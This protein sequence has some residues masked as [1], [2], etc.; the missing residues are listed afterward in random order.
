MLGSKFSFPLGDGC[1]SLVPVESLG[2]EPALR[3]DNL[4]EP[5]D[6]APLLAL[7]LLLFVV[8]AAWI[9]AAQLLYV[10][11]YGPDTPAAPMPFLRD[12]LATSRGWL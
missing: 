1:V 3:R 9:G 12:V 5:L 10:H 7:G 6:A 8:F 2:E 4:L 11:L